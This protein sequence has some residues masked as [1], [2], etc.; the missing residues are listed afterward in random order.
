VSLVLTIVRAWHCA[1]S[2]QSDCK[3]I[4]N[5]GDWSG[6]CRQSLLWLGLPDPAKCIF[7]AMCDDP[8]RELVGDFLKAWYTRFGKT[9]ALVKDVINAALVRGINFDHANDALLEA[10]TDIAVERDGSINRKRL[11]WWIKR[12]AGQVVNGLRFV[13]DKSVSSNTAKWKVESVLSV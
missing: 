6:Y 5:Y 1:E 9:S 2:P 10:I 13:Q 7:E 12:H 8:S 3:A 11:G 4:A